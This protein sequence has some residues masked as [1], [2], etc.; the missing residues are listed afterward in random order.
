[1][2]DDP[3]DIL[4]DNYWQSLSEAES[5]LN[6]ESDLMDVIIDVDKVLDLIQW[7]SIVMLHHY[8]MGT[9]GLFVNVN[10]IADL[11]IRL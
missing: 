3:M 11:L 7:L 2:V 8:L 1:M 10:L 6:L 5:L 9:F 4:Y